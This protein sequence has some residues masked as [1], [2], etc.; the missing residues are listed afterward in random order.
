MLIYMFLCKTGDNRFQMCP[1]FRAHH[2]VTIFTVRSTCI[3]YQKTVIC[4]LG[5]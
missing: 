4:I 5:E 3:R 2:T 1:R